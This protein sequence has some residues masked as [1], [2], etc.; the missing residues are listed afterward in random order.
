MLFKRTFN[1]VHVIAVSIWH[2]GN[3]PV[4]AGSRMAKKHIRNA[5]H[6]L[7][8]VELAH[9]PLPRTQRLVAPSLLPKPQ[10]PVR[11]TEGKKQI[12]CWRAVIF[13]ADS[14]IARR[15]GTELG[16]TITRKLAC[17]M[18]GDVSVTSEPGKGSVFT[19][20]LPAG[21]IH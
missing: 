16:L 3:N 11:Q 7:T 6:H 4:I 18:G 20:R 12:I 8:N 21:T 5:G 10:R 15:F 2:R 17:V 14:L 9:R 19:V 13:H 1:P